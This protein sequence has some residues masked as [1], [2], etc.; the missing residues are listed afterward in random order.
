MVCVSKLGLGAIIIVP[1]DGGDRPYVK[2]LGCD[3]LSKC[4]EGWGDHEEPD[5]T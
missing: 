2:C 1:L 3:R 4:G 5:K